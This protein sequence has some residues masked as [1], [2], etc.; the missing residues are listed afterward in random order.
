MNDW[1]NELTAVI[2]TLYH[3]T[4]KKTTMIPKH[5]IFLHALL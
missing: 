3:L 5:Y 1:R 4:L 2:V